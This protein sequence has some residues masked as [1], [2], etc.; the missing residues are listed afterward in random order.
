MS[1]SPV[2]DSILSARYLRK[3]EQSFEDICHRV[4]SAL[5]DDR[6]EES[7]FFEAMQSLRF[8]PNSRPYERRHRDRPVSACFTLPVTDLIDGIFDAMKQGAIIH[9]TGGEPDI[10]S[11]TSGRRV[12]PSSRPMAWHPVRSHSCGSSTPQPK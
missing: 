6:E 9:K 10:I 4:A 8:L 2:V 5:A 3:G 1:A 12:H 11:R 7:G